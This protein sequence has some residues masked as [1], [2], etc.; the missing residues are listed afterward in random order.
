MKG[1]TNN[2][3]CPRCTLARHLGSAALALVAATMPLFAARQT[4]WLYEEPPPGGYQPN[5]IINTSISA[6]ASTNVDAS[7]IAAGWVAIRTDR[8]PD[9]R[10]R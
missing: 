2:R 10:D 8:V 3:R 7:N 4:G 1:M 6:S 5:P 9:P